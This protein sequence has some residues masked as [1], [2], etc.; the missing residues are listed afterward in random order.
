[1]NDLGTLHSLGFTAAEVRRLEALKRQYQRGEFHEALSPKEL[2]RL[3]FV[4]W[5]VRQGRLSG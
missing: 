4:R 3:E 1:M 2:R 5:L